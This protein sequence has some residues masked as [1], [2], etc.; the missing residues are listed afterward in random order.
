MKNRIISVFLS[1][2]MILTSVIPAMASS[3][4]VWAEGNVYNRI[5]QVKTMF[6]HYS[7]FTASGSSCSHSNG[8][9]CSNCQLSN[10][11]KSKGYSGLNGIF[12]SWT[13]VS[14]ARF[15]F[16][17]TFGVS[18]NASSYSGRA[19]AGA[20][21]TTISNARY[22]D[23]V[24]LKKNGANFHY[25]I[26]LSHYVEDGRTYVN[27][28]DANG[29]ADGTISR[30]NH[31]N[32]YEFA[33]G[34]YILTADN[35]NT[36]ASLA[37]VGTNPQIENTPQ[38]ENLEEV[39]Q[40]DFF[41]EEYLVEN[42]F[43]EEQLNLE[44]YLNFNK[45]LEYNNQFE[46]VGADTWYEDYVKIAYEFGIMT[47]KEENLFDIEGNLTYA[48]AITLASRIHKIF[49]SGTDVFEP[50]TTDKWYDVYVSYALEN[51]I[52]MHSLVDYEKILTRSE[53]VSILSNAIPK[54]TPKYAFSDISDVDR[55]SYYA[56]S[57]YE[58]YNAGILAVSNI[59]EI[60]FNPDDY[61]T[62]IEVATILCRV[63]VR[64]LRV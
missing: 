37:D 17:F 40:E 22:G 32:T 23:M 50:S 10:V 15:A 46:D 16:W 52:L 56:H 53:F 61:I 2:C 24:V 18:D 21:V 60:Q 6:P 57:V 54:L 34:S 4:P 44:G 3:E 39:P 28:L 59:E 26:Y 14:F 31:N 12:E 63:A 48:E 30:V 43:S 33:S 9:T 62:R 47:G 29:T 51:N 11:M 1:V 49:Y 36:I 8:R 13:C 27:I 42:P 64:S 7:F 45:I 55:L 5:E 25:G 35:Y 38:E 58:F 20:S 19:P 41:E